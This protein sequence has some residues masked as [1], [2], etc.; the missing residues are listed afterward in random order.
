[1]ALLPTAHL[2]SRGTAS[3]TT[4]T[5]PVHDPPSP[6]PPLFLFTKK[7]L[8][9]ALA[10][11]YLPC[12]PGWPKTHSK[13]HLPS[14]GVR[15]VWH[16]TTLNMSLKFVFL[17]TWGT[18]CPTPFPNPFLRARLAFLWPAMH[19]L[20]TAGVQVTHY[21]WPKPTDHPSS[22]FSMWRVHTGSTPLLRLPGL[23]LEA[24]RQSQLQVEQRGCVWAYCRAEGPRVAWLDLTDPTLLAAATPVSCHREPAFPHSGQLKLGLLKHRVPCG[25]CWP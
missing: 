14:T 15:D 6:P 5:V 20:L 24:G 19:P 22:R 17:D 3:L 13:P 21:L 1:M 2:C 16:R 25:P 9:I 23:L 4:I 7:F 11:W 18:F 12:D 8:F 10:A